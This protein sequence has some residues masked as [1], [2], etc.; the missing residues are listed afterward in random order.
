M[1]SMWTRILVLSLS[2]TGTAWAQDGQGSPPGPD[3]GEDGKQ[4][5]EEP[6]PDGGPAILPDGSQM[7][8][9]GSQGGSQTYIPWGF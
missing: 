1:M 2:F 5:A 6:P 4:I 3:Y 8:Q 9:G 7:G